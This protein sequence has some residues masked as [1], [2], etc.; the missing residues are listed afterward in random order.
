MTE[1]IQGKV[2]LINGCSFVGKTIFISRLTSLYPH[3]IIVNFELFYK[4]NKEMTALYEEFYSHI[5]NLSIGN[6][7]VISE[8]VCN[9]SDKYCI[10]NNFMNILV[11]P[12]LE[13][14]KINMEKFEEKFGAKLSSIRS[15]DLSAEMMRKYIVLPKKY[16]VYNWE[17]FEQTK[18]AIKNYVGY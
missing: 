15:G 7:L 10:G 3:A 14:H 12:G 6:S 11:D 16:F 13:K 8:S 5:Y 9:Y 4:K 2:I 18:D 17:N 1:T